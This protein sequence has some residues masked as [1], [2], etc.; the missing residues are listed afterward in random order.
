MS[1]FKGTPGPWELHQ[2][3]GEISIRQAGTTE[4]GPGWSS[5]TQIATELNN[6]HDANLVVAAPELLES[7]QEVVAALAELGFD[8]PA[9][10]KAQE[11]INKALGE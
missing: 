1:G 5:Y 2:E 6:I 4:C 11:A 10:R 3:D 8:G 9:E 7:L